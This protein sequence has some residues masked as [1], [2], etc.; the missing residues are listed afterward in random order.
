MTRRIAIVVL[1]AAC[2]GLGLAHH[3]QTGKSAGRSAD[4]EDRAADRAAI[5]KNLQQFL[6]ALGK[7][8]AEA[9]AA[10]WTDSGEY[11]DDDGETIRGRKALT[12]AYKT[13]FARNKGL[14]VDGKLQSLRF[15]G[16]DTA[17]AEGEFFRKSAGKLPASSSHLTAL[18]VREKGEWRLAQIRE[19][20][21]TEPAAS[22]DELKWLIGDWAAK[23]GDRE[24]SIH[25]GWDEKKVF[26]RGRFAVR[27]KGKEVLSGQQIIGVDRA[28][29]VLRS[30]VFESEGG[31]GSGMWERDGK[32]WIIESEGTQADGATTSSVNILT[33]I[34]A[35]SFTWQSQD[36]TDGKDAEPDTVPIKVTRVKKGK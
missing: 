10:F 11:I 19:D 30:W 22:L 6:K 1:V 15:L 36:R 27:E 23:N 33:P 5:Q 16:Q 21:R 20:E 28:A 26:I 14:Q 9:V 4:K 8:D 7:G 13:F 12:A 32:S 35:D 18:L 29:G 24:V 2:A 34:N 3:A 17:V 31:F 25:Y